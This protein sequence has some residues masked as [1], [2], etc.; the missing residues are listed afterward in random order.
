MCVSAVSSKVTEEQLFQQEEAWKVHKTVDLSTF[1]GQHYAVPTTHLD[2]F[3]GS[4][5]DEVSNLDA[6]QI[7]Q[8]N[9]SFP[10]S[11]F[12]GVGEGP[13]GGDLADFN[14]AESGGISGF[15]SYDHEFSG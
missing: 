12:N 5:T 2:N 15:G 9:N 3:Y 14:A 10:P 8:S 13:V 4:E 11:D 7:R 1:E 6:N